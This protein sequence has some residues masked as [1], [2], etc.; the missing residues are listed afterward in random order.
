MIIW[1]WVSQ[2]QYDVRY[3]AEDIFH[4][5]AKC[6]QIMVFVYMGAASGGWSPGLILPPQYA[7]G[8]KESDQVNHCE[9][10]DSDSPDISSRCRKLPDS[11]HCIQHLPADA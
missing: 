7:P 11:H 5:L 9:E 2:V 3:E 10:H 4:R 6:L 8:L 1:I